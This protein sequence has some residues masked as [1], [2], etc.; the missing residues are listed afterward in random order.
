MRSRTGLTV[1][2]FAP[3]QAA[4]RPPVLLVHG[5]GSHGN[6]DWV[7]TGIARAL[8][9]AGR[10]VIVP[11]LRGH[12]DSPA[13]LAADEVAAPA[14][15]TDL[16]AVL[17]EAGADTFDVVGYSLGARLAWELPKTAPGRLRRAVLGGLSPVE[18]F[19]AV[20]VAALHRAVAGG[21][22]PAD[23]FTAA[24]AGMVRAHGARAA[25]LALCVEGLRSTPFTPRTW[26]GRTP[27]VFV[28]GKDDAMTRGIEQVV[29][30][31][32]GA[33]LVTV[34]GD[35]LEV[36]AGAAFRRT[37]LEVLAG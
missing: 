19:E 14:H 12:G 4:A 37:V 1:R 17:D 18:P 2:T 16:V 15:V 22:E 31:L 30:L 11:D 10:V 23:P 35:H 27:P 8:A 24:I 5:F 32:D 3:D 26:A 7:E 21:A 36:L 20:D 6:R 28:V 25:G 13:P 34:P 9:A 29:D 33:E